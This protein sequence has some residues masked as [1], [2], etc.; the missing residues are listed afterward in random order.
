MILFREVF[1]GA[2]THLVEQTHHLLK[3]ERGRE[4]GR[5]EERGGRDINND[6]TLTVGSIIDFYLL[7]QIRQQC[8]HRC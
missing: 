4:G 6:T 7:F 5:G 8:C 3:S 1:A 2:S